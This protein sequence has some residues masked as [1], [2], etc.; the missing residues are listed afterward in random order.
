[1]H[2]LQMHNCFFLCNCLDEFKMTCVF[3]C[4]AFYTWTTPYLH[5]RNIYTYHGQSGLF[6]IPDWVWEKVF[7]FVKLIYSV[8][9]IIQLY[10]T[11]FKCLAEKIAYISWCNNWFLCEITSEKGAQKFHTDDASLLHGHWF[12]LAETNF[13]TWHNQSEALLRLFR[14]YGIIPWSCLRRHFMVKSMVAYHKMLAV[15]SDYLNGSNI[16]I[17]FR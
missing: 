4:I 11:G 17:F 15:F 2:F 10:S 8:N 12:W 16:I 3:P 14:Q 1:M 6:S 5:S 9:T 13:D 7:K